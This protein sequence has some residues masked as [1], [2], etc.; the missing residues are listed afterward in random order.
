MFPSLFDNTNEDKNIIQYISHNQESLKI[1]IKNKLTTLEKTL[2]VIAAGVKEAK[3]KN[4]PAVEKIWNMAGYINTCSLDLAVV[5]EAL[6]FETDSWKKR[7]YARMGAV[8]MYEATVDIP[9]MI[10]KD[11]RSMVLTLPD[12]DKFIEHLTKKLKNLNNFKVNHALW[13]KDIR[14]CCAAHRDQQ[15]SEQLR[16]VFEISPTKVL[17]L[18]AEFDSLLNELG[19]SFQI[20]MKLLPAK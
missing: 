20:G 5:G 10:G 3:R 18:I 11:F 14:V 4:L 7:Y 6:M 16:I 12:G 1:D 19:V 2:E 9:K 15:L 17:T 8:N 13:L